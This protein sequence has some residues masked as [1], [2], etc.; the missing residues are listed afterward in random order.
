MHLQPQNGI[1][2]Y[3]HL[4]KRQ[5]S[6]RQSTGTCRERTFLSAGTSR[7]LRG[8]DAGNGNGQGTERTHRWHMPI[9]ALASDV[10]I[11]W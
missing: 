11:N 7:A 6:K 9:S 1:V 5:L 2:G 10:H 8:R 4:L 3:G